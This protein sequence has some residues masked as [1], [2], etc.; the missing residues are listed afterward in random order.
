MSV[1]TQRSEQRPKNFIGDGR[2]IVSD[3]DYLFD[4]SRNF[5][6]E[7]FIYR[8]LFHIHYECWQTAIL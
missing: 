7:T 1:G 6:V 4:G 3:N 2:A 5:D 8:F